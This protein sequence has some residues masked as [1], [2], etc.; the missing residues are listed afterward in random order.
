MLIMTD[1]N[2]LEPLVGCVLAI[3]SPLFIA[4]GYVLQRWK[5]RDADVDLRVDWVDL[6]TFVG[7]CIAWI[8]QVIAM[9]FVPVMLVRALDM[10][11]VLWTVVGAVWFLG[12][13]VHIWQS[14]GLCLIGVGA[15]SVSVISL[16]LRPE[17]VDE[18]V[19]LVFSRTN[20]I[21]TSAFVVGTVATVVCPVLTKP[22]RWVIACALVNAA[23]GLYGRY[24]T[25][26]MTEDGFV[27][28]ALLVLASGTASLF[29]LWFRKLALRHFEVR[30]VAALV[31]VILLLLSLVVSGAVLGEF[32][33][34]GAVHYVLVVVASAAMVVGV[35]CNFPLSFTS[36]RLGAVIG[37]GEPGEL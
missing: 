29:S 5:V 3:G 22:L 7:A 28:T 33:D 36:I 13:R 2:I 10:T 25:R 14:F 20:Y 32:Q 27:P 26:A 37:T 18:M 9:K 19:P 34:F 35:Y 1:S 24:T 8:M 16:L 31:E 4:F 21:V 15:V 23:C 30:L 11:R 12:E 6:V 17:D